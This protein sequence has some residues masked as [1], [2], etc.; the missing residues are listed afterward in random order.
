MRLAYSS[1]PMSPVLVTGS[2]RPLRY[3]DPVNDG[4]IRQ[5]LLDLRI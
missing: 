2:F 5:P 1:F 4:G 3:L